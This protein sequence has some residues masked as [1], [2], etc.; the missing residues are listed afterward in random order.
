MKAIR[1]LFLLSRACHIFFGGFPQIP[2]DIKE[3]LLAFRL[4]F[5][6]ELRGFHLSP[7]KNCKNHYS[8]WK[9]LKWFSSNAPKLVRWFAKLMSRYPIWCIS[10]MSWAICFRCSL[11]RKF[12]SFGMRGARVR[13][14]SKASTW[15]SSAML[16]ITCMLYKADSPEIFSNIFLQSSPKKLV[17]NSEFQPNAWFDVFIHFTNWWAHLWLTNPSNSCE[18]TGSQIAPK[19]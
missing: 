2:H 11:W 17:G 19:P 12:N 4:L 7:G 10:W 13:L 18:E 15:R 3:I 6:E 16:C 14:V 9:Q 5:R 1:F 8:Q